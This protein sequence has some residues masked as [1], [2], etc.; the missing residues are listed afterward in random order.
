ML[1]F[2]GIIYKRLGGEDEERWERKDMWTKMLKH[3]KKR[4]PYLLST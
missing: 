3:L 4:I 1:H 2:D